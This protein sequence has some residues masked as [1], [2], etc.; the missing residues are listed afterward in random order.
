MKNKIPIAIGFSMLLVVLVMI[1]FYQNRDGVQTSANPR[2]PQSSEEPLHQ[3][4]EPE[5]LRPTIV[6]GD[7]GYSLQ[8]DD[9]NITYD[10]GENWIL[11]P[12]EKELL[13]SG[14]YRGNQQQLIDNSFILSDDHAV[15][16]YAY[17]N[18][19]NSPVKHIY[20]DNQG[21]TWD[22]VTITEKGLGLRFRKIKMLTDDFWYV[23][24]SGSR[25]MSQEGALIF[26]SKD[27]GQNWQSINMPATT[28]LVADG[29]FV[30]ETTAFM[31]YGMINPQE[32][33]L[34]VTNNAGETWKE[35]V[36][37]MPSK[38]DRVF[39]MPNTP[40]KEKDHLA[41][42]VDQ[43]PNGDYMGGLI[44]GKFISTDNG[45]TWTFAEEVEPEIEEIG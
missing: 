38:Y 45:L 41:M 18:G 34:Y 21:E 31:S 7:I 10:G 4:Q 29:G 24:I 1:P 37:H 2:E 28:R 23:V 15:F 20:S 14:E 6:D 32:P 11:V 13:F 22:E 25:K 12:I 26:F 3:E 27:Q 9:L 33:E 17:G 8:N 30:D 43:G 40:Y 35:A 42:L 19:E 16:L 36:F 39:V 44:Q 5:P